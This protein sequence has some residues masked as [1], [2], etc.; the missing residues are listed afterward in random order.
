VPTPVKTETLNNGLGAAVDCVL[1]GVLKDLV[2]CIDGLGDWG[3]IGD[4]VDTRAAD[5]KDS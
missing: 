3:D 2:M 5:D 4:E 1:T